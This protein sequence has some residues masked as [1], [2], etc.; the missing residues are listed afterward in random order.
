MPETAPGAR[1]PFR[2]GAIVLAAGGSSRMGTVKQLLELDGKPLIVRAADA[3][4]GSPA[5]PVV[6]VVGAH[7]EMVRAPIARHPVSVVFNPEWASGLA[8]SIRVGLAA[9]LAAEPGLD[10]VLVALCDQPALFG[11]GHLAALGA[12][13]GDEGARRMLN[14]DPEGVAAADLPEMGAD[15]DTPAD[16]RGWASRH[17]KPRRHAARGCGV[18]SCSATRRRS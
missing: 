7:A 15:L 5:R 11:R 2:L 6:V 4:L 1:P 10:A 18:L 16:C 8:S 13:D 17:S 12:L 14:G 3:V 9:L